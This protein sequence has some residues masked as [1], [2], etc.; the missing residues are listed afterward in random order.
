[1]LRGASLAG[2]CVGGRWNGAAQLYVSI[3]TPSFDSGMDIDVE[4]VNRSEHD[5]RSSLDLGKGDEG[6]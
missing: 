6:H 3:A 4:T 5:H 1:M 2:G